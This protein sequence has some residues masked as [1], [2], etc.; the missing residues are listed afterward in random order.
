MESYVNNKEKMEDRTRLVEKLMLVLSALNPFPSRQ[1][2]NHFLVI[3]HCVIVSNIY[4]YIYIYI[5]VYVYI[6]VYIYICVSLFLKGKCY[7]LKG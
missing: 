7:D 3:K 2:G 4:I 6:Y 5:Y 1:E